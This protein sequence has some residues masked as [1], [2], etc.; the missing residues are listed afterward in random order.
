MKKQLLLIC[1]FLSSVIVVNAQFELNAFGIAQNTIIRNTELDE[2]VL[3]NKFTLSSSAGLRGMYFTKGGFGFGGC[4][5]YTA[6]NQK[7]IANNPAADTTIYK[8]KRRLDYIR[9]AALAAYKVT[10]NDQFSWHV[11]GGPQ[12]ALLIKGDGAIPVYTY[13]HNTNY[14]YFDVPV[15]TSKYYNPYA[16]EVVGGIGFDYLFNRNLGINAG[17]RVDYGMT[18]IENKSYYNKMVYDSRNADNQVEKVAL[19][20]VG[21]YYGLTYKFGSTHL[22]APSQKFGK[23][24]SFSKGRR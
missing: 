7:F 2:N 21:I 10:M 4:V 24:K 23:K 11:F 13:D 6:H 5:M 3:Q 17:F 14:F 15:A 19:T 20:T 12:I 8:G 9:I 22:S 16:I 18:G 1:I